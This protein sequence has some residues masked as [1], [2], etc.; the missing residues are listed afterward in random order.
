MP[1]NDIPQEILRFIERLLAFLL[2]FGAMLHK[3][4]RGG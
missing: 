4:R 1:R 3:N 2:I